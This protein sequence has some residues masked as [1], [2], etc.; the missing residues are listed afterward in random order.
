LAATWVRLRTAVWRRLAVVGSLCLGIALLLTT[1]DG[2]GFRY[3]LLYSLLIGMACTVVVDC[4]RLCAAWWVDRMRKA[5]GLVVQDSAAT[6]GWR[7]AVP[8][9]ILALLVGPP[10]GHWLG[11]QI[12]GFSSPSMFALDQ[13]GS[14]FILFISLGATVI[15]LVVISTQESLASARTL[16]EAAQ[17]QAAETQLR[18]LQSQLEPHMLFNTLANLR[19][20][21]GLDPVR[22]Q[23]ML[24]HLIA[25]LRATLSASRAAAH[26]LA[27]EFERVDDYLALMAVRMGPR[28]Q[29]QLDLPEAL[30]TLSVPPM[31]L[32]PLV[33]NAIKHGLEPKVQGGRIEVQARL[34]AG[35]LCLRVRDTGVGLQPAPTP[36]TAAPGQAPAAPPP[37]LPAH[38]SGGFG[39]TQVRERLA[40]LYGPQASAVLACATD[41][42]G[43]TVATLL[44]PL[45]GPA[46][47][48]APANS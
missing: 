29:V 8:G 25:Y 1:M 19:V 5:R 7:G 42:E 31:L 32:Q 36:L 4:T 22:A 46:A 10:F 20:L 39:M 12:T 24:D 45:A 34:Q 2:G 35:Q 47:A 11:D 28:L 37:T 3:K 9:T 33:E 6:T 38:A 41:A 27:T 30:R 23:A 18:L 48:A 16:A 43:G 44:L 13:P 14:R 40:T 17:R 26:P 21:V 15:S